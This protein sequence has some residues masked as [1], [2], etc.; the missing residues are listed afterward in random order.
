MSLQAG[1]YAVALAGGLE[2][3]TSA[4]TRLDGKELVIWRD[5]AGASHVWEDRCPHRG[6]RLSFGF[7]RGSHIACLYHGWQYDEAGLCRYIPAHPKLEVPDTIRV[8]TYPSL[9]AAGLLWV[10]SGPA[11]AAPAAPPE[12]L[13]GVPVRS[14]YVDVAP[15]VV[16]TALDGLALGS[17]IRQPDGIF[18]T[19]LDGA[20]VRLAWQPFTENRTALHILL[21]GETATPTAVAL[22]AEALRGALEA[23]PVPLSEV[24]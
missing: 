24:A 8:A 21:A 12:D 5:T 13:P 3:G 4:G 19:E 16:A 6:M 14:L 23:L 9:E 11:E 1:W 20:E 15:E 2:P 18:L 17:F 7:V 22:W 10:W